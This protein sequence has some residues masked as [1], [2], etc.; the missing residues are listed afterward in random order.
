[1]HQ[2]TEQQIEETINRISIDA[3]EEIYQR[4]LRNFNSCVKSCEK[5]DSSQIHAIYI[6]SMITTIEL[7][8]VVLT[9]TLIKL[10]CNEPD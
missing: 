2:L 5:H 9:E 8:R 7:S 1:M 3:D 10:F 4:F 6:A